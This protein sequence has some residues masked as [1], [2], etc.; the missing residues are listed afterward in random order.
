MVFNLSNG[1]S[2]AGTAVA[3]TAGAVTLEAQKADL[4]KQKLVLADQLAGAREE[5]G[6]VFTT[7]EREAGQ[8][9]TGGQNDLTRQNQLETTKMH[10]AG[11]LGAAGIGANASLTANR[12]RIAGESALEDKKSAHE[13]EKYKFIYGSKEDMAN[14]KNLSQESIAKIRGDLTKDL[15]ASMMPSPDAIDT[16]AQQYRLTGV[17]PALGMGGAA[18]KSAIM[19]KADEMDKAE[20][21]TPQDRIAGNIDAKTASSTLQAT[22]KQLA[23][24]ESFAG[25]ME[26]QMKIINEEIKKSGDPTGVT[27][28]NQWVNGGRRTFA[29]DKSDSVGALGAA[30]YGLQVEAAKIAS[31]SLG[32]APLSDAARK[33]QQDNLNKYDTVDYLRGVMQTYTAE[34]DNR[35]NNIKTTLQRLQQRA[36]GSQAPPVPNQP[37]ATRENPSAYTPMTAPAPSAAPAGMVNQAPAAIPLPIKGGVPDETKLETDKAYMWPPP[38]GLKIYKGNGAWIDP[39]GTK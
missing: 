11:Q 1:L 23:A 12:E 38:V 5:K 22:Q 10:V 34:K 28:F 13:M 2:A 3:A 31:G 30:I 27:L 24:T 17:L 33:E 39:A 15:H 19:S 7:S 35:L 8:L 9:F 6:R 21:R 29:T 25:T 36:S 18:A 16:A 14:Q 37:A 4:E 32:N 20:G 26:D